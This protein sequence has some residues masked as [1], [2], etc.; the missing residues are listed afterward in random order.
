MLPVRTRRKRVAIAARFADGNIIRPK[1]KENGPTSNSIR[2]DLHG[3]DG[4]VVRRDGPGVR[5]DGGTDMIRIYQGPVSPDRFDVL[6]VDNE[7]RPTGESRQFVSEP[8]A[9][10]LEE[11]RDEEYQTV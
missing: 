10:I 6:A 5:A 2:P 4:S 1:G 11:M 8:L 3:H 9:R 7:G